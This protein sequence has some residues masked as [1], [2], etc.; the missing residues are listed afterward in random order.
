MMLKG[1]VEERMLGRMGG[2]YGVGNGSNFYQGSNFNKESKGSNFDKG[3]I[4]IMGLIRV[5]T[6]IKSPIT[7]M[8]IRVLTLA[9]ELISVN[10]ITIMDLALRG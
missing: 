7:I 2:N 10:P 9:K 1:V 6:S 4:T 8:R 3:L 5:K